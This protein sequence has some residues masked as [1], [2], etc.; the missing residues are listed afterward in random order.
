M[1]KS[2]FTIINTEAT[3]LFEEKSRLKN[4][5]KFQ[6]SFDSATLSGHTYKRRKIAFLATKKREKMMKKI[7]G[8][9]S[10]LDLE[11]FKKIHS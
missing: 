9:R 4:F 3:K 10:K 11:N 7:K 8:S 2:R 5:R 6:M 1:L